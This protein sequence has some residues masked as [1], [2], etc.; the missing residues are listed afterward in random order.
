MVRKREAFGVFVLNTSAMETCVDP[1]MQLFL[2][3][4]ACL[5]AHMAGGFALTLNQLLIGVDGKA[6]S[7]YA[8]LV[9]PGGIRSPFLSLSPP[10]PYSLPCRAVMLL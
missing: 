7:N 3:A 6:D 2:E 10:I 8:G 1:W 5:P 4:S 9:L